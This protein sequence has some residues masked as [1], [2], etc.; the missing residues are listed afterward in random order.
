MAGYHARGL[1]LFERTMQLSPLDA[2]A[3]ETYFGIALLHFFAGR[4]EEAIGW[5]NKALGEKPEIR[6]AVIKAAAM[7]A[8]DHP[9]GEVQE[10]VQRLLIS[11]PDLSIKAVRQR[12]FSFRRV[13][14][15]AFAAGLRKAGLPE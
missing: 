13:D 1:A 14:V 6:S 3:F 10:F 5:A 15:E 12:M 4:F 2:G 9:R 8:A 7:A 11:A